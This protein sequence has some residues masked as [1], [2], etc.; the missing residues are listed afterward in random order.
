MNYVHLLN[1][2][3]FRLT[4]IEYQGKFSIPYF[5]AKDVARLLAYE[6][7]YDSIQ[8]KCSSITMYKCIGS[9]T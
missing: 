4:F 6:M 8:C 9:E 7:R 3:S 2:E 1:F 5:E